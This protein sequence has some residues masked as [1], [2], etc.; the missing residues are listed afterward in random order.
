MTVSKVSEDP[1]ESADG[2]VQRDPDPE[3]PESGV[4]G[5]DQEPDGETKFQQ[6]SSPS[7]GARASQVRQ[8]A[9]YSS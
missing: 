7:Q 8:P 6:R 9:E 5:G 1:D 3:H 4:S 2:K